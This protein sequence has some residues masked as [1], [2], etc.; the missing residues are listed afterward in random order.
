MKVEI[1][2]DELNRL[3]SIEALYSVISGSRRSAH[4]SSGAC[5][6]EYDTDNKY[7]IAVMP[8]GQPIPKQISL[9]LRDRINEPIIAI[10]EMH[11]DLTNISNADPNSS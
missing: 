7:L 10:V 1:D 8:D 11:V 6:I 2:L 4:S 3:K 9:V 5:R